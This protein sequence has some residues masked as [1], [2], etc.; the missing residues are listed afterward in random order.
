MTSRE[1]E[2]KRREEK[3]LLQENKKSVADLHHRVELIPEKDLEMQSSSG[4]D[5]ERSSV[6]KFSLLKEKEIKSNK[7]LQEMEQEKINSRNLDLQGGAKSSK[8]L[9]R[10]ISL[11]S[12]QC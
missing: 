9:L 2:A 4:V 8:F 3:L 12:V 10:V 11:F 1:C 5:K 7:A 6:K